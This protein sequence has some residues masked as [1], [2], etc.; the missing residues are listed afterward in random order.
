MGLLVLFL[1]EA[2][3]AC[4]FSAYPTLCQAYSG[5]EAVF[6]GK[7]VKVERISPFA[8]AAKFEVRKSYKGKVGTTEI[9]E[10]SAGCGPDLSALGE[11][12]FV[13]KEEPY[14]FG[15]ADLTSR[16]S[17]IPEAIKYA[18]SMSWN[19][20]VFA[21]GGRVDLPPNDLKKVRVSI[22][23]RNKIY[24]APIDPK[25]FFNFTTKKA[26]NYTVKISLPFR[27]SILIEDFG[28]HY[29][30]V[31][32]DAS[33]YTVSFRPNECNYRTFEVTSPGRAGS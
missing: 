5:A 7:L 21:I 15:P 2:V 31:E 9:A 29:D 4:T 26:A 27:A 17:R 11:D 3:C 14:R 12:Y 23:G 28:S 24:N 13:F 22:V 10:F 25:G 8:V 18:E 19:K 32:S 6:I 16:V 30:I 1:G 33:S 20:P